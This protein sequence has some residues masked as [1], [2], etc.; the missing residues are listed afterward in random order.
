MKKINPKKLAITLLVL[1]GICLVLI[2]AIR[3]YLDHSHSLKENS[4]TNWN[5]VK[6]KVSEAR[7]ATATKAQNAYDKSKDTITP[8][9][10]NE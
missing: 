2:L 9:H 4:S 7:N 10:T 1:G 6:E 3:P 8:E 5:T